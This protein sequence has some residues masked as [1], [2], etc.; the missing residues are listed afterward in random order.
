MCQ[1]SHRHIA[2]P[3]VYVLL[4]F[5]RRSSPSH[6]VA[7]RTARSHFEDSQDAQDAVF[8]SMETRVVYINSPT[9]P[10]TNAFQQGRG[11][12]RLTF[13]DVG[14]V[15]SAD[16]C[17]QSSATDSNTMDECFSRKRGRGAS[18]AGR[19]VRRRVETEQKDVLHS[20]PS[21][22]YGVRGTRARGRSRGQGRQ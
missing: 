20:A 5:P 10:P 22:S 16:T 14:S 18:S 21:T 8:E 17:T 1:L 9:Y 13:K 11:P 7:L 6:A 15:D 12:P 19:V 4:L 2:S 3:V